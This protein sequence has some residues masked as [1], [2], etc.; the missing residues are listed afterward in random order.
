MIKKLLFIAILM[1][2]NIYAHES[3]KCSDALRYGQYWMSAGDLRFGEG[4]N[5]MEIVDREL[6]RS[7]PDQQLLCGFSDLSLMFHR[8]A[9]ENY[10]KASQSY[11]QAVTACTGN[12]QTQA[13]DA[14]TLSNQEAIKAT[15]SF[16]RAQNIYFQFNC[17]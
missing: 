11:L 6:S 7:T 5:R 2:S 8:E 16:R 1:S 15:N 3:S 13:Q 9:I 10:N 12:N 4:D 14:A 17:Q